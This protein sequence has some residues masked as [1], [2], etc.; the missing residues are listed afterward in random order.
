MIISEK[1]QAEGILLI[2]NIFSGLFPVLTVIAYTNHL[3]PLSTLTWSYIVATIFFAIIL[4]VKKEWKKNIT[5]IQAIKD[6]VMAT[7]FIA[8]GYY[9]LYYI[10]LSLTS[11]QNVALISMTEAAFSFLIIGWIAK[12]E[13]VSRKHLFGAMLMLFAAGVVLFNNHQTSINIGDLL[14]FCAVIIAPIGN[15]FAKRALHQVSIHYLL[16]IRSLAGVII[17]S[18]ASLI[19]EK[20]IPFEVILKSLP[21][22]LYSGL[23]FLGLMK[24]VN[25]F[26]FKKTSVTH[27]ISFNSLAPVFTF[28]FAWM[29]LKNAPSTVQIFAI[30]PSLFGLFLLTT[31]K[32]KQTQYG[33]EKT[34]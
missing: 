15:I 18:I 11:P 5:N 12:K 9:L 33:F 19:F 10:A 1:R 23:V 16:F 14:M 29:I 27:T 13:P 25:F 2:K 21:Y 24:M 22:L 28:I 7:L 3:L 31:A 8:I 26:S 20:T 17:F 30:I 6:I 4:T 34:V 32:Q